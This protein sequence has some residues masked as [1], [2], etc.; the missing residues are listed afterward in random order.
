MRTSSLDNILIN[1]PVASY[2]LTSATPSSPAISTKFNTLSTALSS[3]SLL[4]LARLSSALLVPPFPSPF[5][6]ALRI[7]EP[8][9]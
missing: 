4:A 3:I 2:T 6:L 5:P 9:H 7:A 8:V 1:A